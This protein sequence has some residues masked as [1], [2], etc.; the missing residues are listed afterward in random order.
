MPVMLEGSESTV[1]EQI[2]QCSALR[3]GISYFQLVMSVS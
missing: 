3:F 2:V 1:I